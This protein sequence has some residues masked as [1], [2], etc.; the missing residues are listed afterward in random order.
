[1]LSCSIWFTAPSLW[2]GGGLVSR[3]VGRVYGAAGAVRLTTTHGTIRTVNTTYA[4]TL[5]TITNP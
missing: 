3:C 5:K 4:A 2:L 1:M